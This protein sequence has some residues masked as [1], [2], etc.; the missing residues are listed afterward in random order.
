MALHKTTVDPN[1]G[2]PLAYHRISSVNLIT[3]ESMVIQVCSYISEMD[4]HREKQQFLA[5]PEIAEPIFSTVYYYS[6]EYTDGMTC[7][8][9][10]EYLKTLPEFADATDV[11]EDE[12]EDL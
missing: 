5:Q 9:A 10:Y 12:H 6:C 4:R 3:N 1:T 11:L 2:I 8:Q 7:T